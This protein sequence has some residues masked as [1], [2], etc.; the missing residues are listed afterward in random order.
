MADAAETFL[1]DVKH[2]KDLNKIEDA[3]D[4]IEITGLANLRQAV[5]HR[6]VTQPGSLAHRPTYGVGLKDFQNAP[7]TLDSQR[8]LLKRLKNQLPLDARVKE[9]TGLSVEDID[10]L[11]GGVKIIVKIRAVGY[12]EIIPVEI[13]LG[14][15]GF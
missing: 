15:G 13:P 11:P 4:V 7:N 14:N 8:E 1:T 5:I 6:I 2:T 10:N 3:G 9:V 12:D